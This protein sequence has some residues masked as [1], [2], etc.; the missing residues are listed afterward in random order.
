MSAR[1]YLLTLPGNSESTPHLV[2]GNTSFFSLPFRDSSML[3][4]NFGLVL[5]EIVSASVSKR[6]L[7]D[8]G[9]TAACAASTGP[10]ATSFFLLG[11]TA[12]VNPSRVRAPRSSMSPFSANTTSSTVKCLSSLIIAKPMLRVT[13]CPF[14]ITTSTS[15]F[16]RAT[17]IFSSVAAGTQVYSLPVSTNT[18]VNTAERSRSV[19]FS[20]LHRTKKV[21]MTNLCID[22]TEE[23]NHFARRRQDRDAN[24]KLIKREQ[25]KPSPPFARSVELAERSPPAGRRCLLEGTANSAASILRSILSGS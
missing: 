16:S 3:L 9:V 2:T 10:E 13:R 24:S 22:L 20:I 5:S 21:P 11:S 14:A 6:R 8:D 1:R 7:C 25:A 18:L 4:R 15:F 17:P 12:R 19:T 23:Y